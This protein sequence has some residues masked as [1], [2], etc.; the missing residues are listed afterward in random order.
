MRARAFE[1]LHKDDGEEHQQ[2]NKHVVHREHLQRVKQP[3]CTAFAPQQRYSPSRT[4]AEREGG[5]EEGMREG[6]ERRES[7]REK[8]KESEGAK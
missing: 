8:E 2:A 3:S 5:A 4:P 6:G 7:E 1:H